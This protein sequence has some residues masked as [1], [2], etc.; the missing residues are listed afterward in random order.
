MDQSGNDEFN[1]E[2]IVVHN[3]WEKHKVIDVKF[4]KA[5]HGGGDKR[6]QD[7]IFVN[8]KTP[9]P[10]DRAAGIRDGAMSILIGIAARKSIES[11]SPVRIA[12][13]TDLEPRDKRIKT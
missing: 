10:Y 9:D 12:E 1:I 11:K 6:L 3:L 5:G 13:L 4:S 2:P 8:S 7:K